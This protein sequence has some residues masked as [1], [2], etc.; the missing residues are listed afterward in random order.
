MAFETG[1]VPRVYDD[2]DEGDTRLD[3][4]ILSGAP[5]DGSYRGG[6]VL[7]PAAIA[8]VLTSARMSAT[9]AAR[10]LAANAPQRIQIH[11][12]NQ[13]EPSTPEQVRAPMRQ[14]FRHQ[15]SRVEWAVAI[16]AGLFAAI[17]IGAVAALV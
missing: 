17:V 6:T 7:M 13:P 8:P 10:Y 15:P 14:G 9:P 1:A 11:I 12:A 16:G 2:V 3:P 5:S 4:G